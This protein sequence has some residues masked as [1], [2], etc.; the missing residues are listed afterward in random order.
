[1]E[2]RTLKQ[3]AYGTLAIAGLGIITFLGLPKGSETIPNQ[4]YQG[5][6]RDQT[7]GRTQLVFHPEKKE[8][9]EEDDEPYKVYGDLS[10]LDLDSEELFGTSYDLI[11]KI[12]RL[13]PR[14]IVNAT[15]VEE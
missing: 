12:P 13:G 2:K 5:W 3:I 8:D 10:R 11:I 6:N 15:L 4:I 14:E 9:R 7:N 1:M